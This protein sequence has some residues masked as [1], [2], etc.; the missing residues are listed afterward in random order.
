[1]NKLLTYDAKRCVR[2]LACVADCPTRSIQFTGE[3]LIFNGDSCCAC[4]SCA[5]ICPVGALRLRAEGRGDAEKTAS[6]GGTADR[7]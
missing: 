5:E 4:Y 3:T 7:G 6:N 1:M 2:C